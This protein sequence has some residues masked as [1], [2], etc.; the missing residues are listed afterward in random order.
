VKRFADGTGQLWKYRVWQVAS[1]AAAIITVAFMSLWR[2]NPARLPEGLTIALYFPI[3]I[4]WFAW[5]VSAIRCPGCGASPVWYQM[6]HG[7]ADDAVDRIMG[8]HVCPA[9]RYDP[10]DPAALVR[11]MSREPDLLS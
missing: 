6:R 4:F 9:C 8:Y 2:G 11:Q 1:L 7:R 10:T 5:W 3:C